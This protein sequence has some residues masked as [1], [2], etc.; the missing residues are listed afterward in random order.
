MSGTM[1][2][3]SVAGSDERAGSLAPAGLQIRERSARPPAVW[4]LWTAAAGSG[5]VGLAGFLP[6]AS[7][8]RTPRSSFD[9]VRLADRLELVSTGW[10]EQLLV[11]WVMVPFLAAL[12]LL[13]AALGRP[14]P[15]LVATSLASGLGVIAVAVVV[16]TPLQLRPGVWIALAGSLIGLGGITS[17]VIRVIALKVHRSS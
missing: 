17:L 15:V 9:L 11:L 16:R 4:P 7:T 3:M 13:A 2:E 10:H 12:G 8:G 14:R 1:A 5:V 6:W